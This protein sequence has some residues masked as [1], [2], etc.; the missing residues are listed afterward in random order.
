MG[1]C[2]SAEDLDLDD[3]MPSD[4]SQTLFYLTLFSS[5]LC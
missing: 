4:V 2:Q 1:A 5:I 3:E